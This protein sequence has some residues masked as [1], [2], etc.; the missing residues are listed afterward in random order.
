MRNFYKYRRLSASSKIVFTSTV[1]DH[2]FDMKD[3]SRYILSSVCLSHVCSFHGWQRE[4]IRG[5]REREDNDELKEKKLLKK[6]CKRVTSSSL[7]MLNNINFLNL[8]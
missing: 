1:I 2:T 3:R 6:K 7:A 4:R 5:E 8:L